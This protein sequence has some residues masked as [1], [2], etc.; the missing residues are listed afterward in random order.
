[1]LNIGSYYQN[2]PASVEIYYVLLWYSLDTCIIKQHI[3]DYGSCFRVPTVRVCCTLP[4]C[5]Q[6]MLA[7]LHIQ[8]CH[9]YTSVAGA[10][11][12]LPQI[13]ITVIFLVS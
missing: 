5:L 8:Y 1:M 13:L 9:T 3:Q 12:G 2:T 6:S 11:F 7:T 10:R 4:R